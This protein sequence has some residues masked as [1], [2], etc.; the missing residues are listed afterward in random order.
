MNDFEA[1]DTPAFTRLPVELLERILD[2][3]IPDKEMYWYWRD[4]YASIH[5]SSV[6]GIANADTVSIRLISSRYG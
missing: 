4:L 1:A 5:C 6:T 3:N 2:Y